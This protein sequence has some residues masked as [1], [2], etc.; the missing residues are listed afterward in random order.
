MTTTTEPTANEP[1]A[2][3]PTPAIIREYRIWMPRWVRRLP[4]WSRVGAILFLLLAA[5]VWVRSRY[6]GGQFWMDE[7][8]AVGI[9]SH[10]LSAIPGVLRYDGS[11]PLYYLILHIWMSWF[12]NGEAA[13][14]WLSILFAELTVPIAYWGGLS[15]TRSRRAALTCA[16]LFAFN[17]FLDYYALETRMYTLMALFGL[18]A[19]IGFVRGFVF[20][21]RKYV[22]LFAASLALMLYTHNWGL[23]FGAGSFLS[24][25]VLYYTGDAEI[26]ENLVRDAL[27]AFVGA[28]ILFVPWIPNFFFQTVHTAAPWDTR[29][30]FG[31]FVQIA[32]GI[33]GGGSIAV[34]ML[35]SAGVGYSPMF[36]KPRNMTRQTRVALMLVTIAAFTLATAWIASQVITPAW[37]VRY[38]APVVPPILLL[39]G[40]GIS[41]AGVIGAVAL[42]F[43]ICFMAR[44]SAFEPQYKSDMQDIAGEVKSD[45]HPGDLVIVGQPEQTPL[46]YY[47]LPGGLR[48]ANTIGAV[49]DPSYMNWVNAMKRYRAADPSKVVPKLLNSVKPGQQVLFIRPLTEGVANWE[50]PWTSLVRRRT[51]E[52]FQIIDK[53]KQFKEEAWAPHNY[54]GACCIADSAVLYVKK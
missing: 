36:L 26:R 5:S 41:R 24:L 40:I 13:T 1:T 20:R 51:A 34:V 14:H 21:E 27:A 37:V 45:L 22:L 7:A 2:G 32:L 38:F 3:E 25:I 54:R 18:L 52:W 11:P 10:S 35:L 30:R 29:P 46:A 39:L 12:G 50:A 23:F 47:Y 6:V 9:S 15:F 16:T 33:L 4:T 28:A 19:T 53:D 49:K 42:I 17:G 48:F 8:I 44:P 43:I 31:V